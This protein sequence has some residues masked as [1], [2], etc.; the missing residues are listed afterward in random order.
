MI[1]F[2]TYQLV[3]FVLSASMFLYMGVAWLNW[4]IDGVKGKD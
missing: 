1:R 4:F 3:T 2:E